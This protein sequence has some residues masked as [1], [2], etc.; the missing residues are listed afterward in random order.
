MKFYIILGIAAGLTIAAAI[1]ALYLANLNEH[2]PK[3]TPT[4][5][6][7]HSQRYIPAWYW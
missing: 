5:A 2:Q 6:D 4:R 3:R 7:D 1:I